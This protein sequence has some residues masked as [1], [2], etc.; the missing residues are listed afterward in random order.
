[1]TVEA[2]EVYRAKLPS[3]VAALKA[4]QSHDAVHQVEHRQTLYLKVGS[5][6]VAA[7]HTRRAHKA[8]EFPDK[9]SSFTPSTKRV[10]PLIVKYLANTDD[11]AEPR[12]IYQEI[13]S[14]QVAA[15][16]LAQEFN[17]V[18]PRGYP[19]NPLCWRVAD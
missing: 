17:K 2:V 1:M 7:G 10:R 8:L 12:G 16:Y 5:T 15:I 11:E 9:Q 4:L 19:E 18:K 3:S 6:P 14:N 13:L